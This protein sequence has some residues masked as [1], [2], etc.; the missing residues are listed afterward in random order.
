MCAKSLNSINQLRLNS[1]QLRC[2]KHSYFVDKHDIL[3]HKM[4]YVRTKVIIEIELTFHKV[5]LY[6]RWL[7]GT[8]YACA[9]HVESRLRLLFGCS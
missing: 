6:F 5:R 2:I 3:T 1:R 8:L 9:L 7:R 4:K